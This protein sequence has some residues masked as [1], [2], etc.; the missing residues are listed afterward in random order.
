MRLAGSAGVVI[1]VAALTAPA[2][3]QAPE[4]VVSVDVAK[5]RPPISSRFS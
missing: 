2:R 5:V 4:A 1:V 3:A